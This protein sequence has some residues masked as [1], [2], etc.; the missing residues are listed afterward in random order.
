MDENKEEKLPPLTEF[1]SKYLTNINM[2]DGFKRI[3]ESLPGLISFQYAEG[4][5]Y[6]FENPSLPLTFVRFRRSS[7]P[8]ENGK[9]YQQL[10]SKT[11]EAD[12][13]NNIQRK[14]PNLMVVGSID[15]VLGFIKSTGF[16]YTHSIKKQCHIYKYPDCTLVFYGVRPE[17]SEEM[18]YFVEIEVDEET[19]HNLTKNEAIQVIEKYEQILSSIEGVSSRKRLKLSLRER[20]RNK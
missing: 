5:D 15:E 12:S 1:E 6:F 11:K 10:T 8:D 18:E 3:S 13:S 14:E 2:L 16:T 19:I 17:N 7:Y 20:Y 4:P 9:Y